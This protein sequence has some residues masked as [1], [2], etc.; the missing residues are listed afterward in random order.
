MARRLGVF[1]GAFSPVHIGHLLAARA[2]AEALR[3]DQVVFVPTGRSAFAKRLWPDARR[4]ACLRAALKGH[5]GF[6][7][8][9]RELR[10][11]G[12]SYTVDTLRALKAEQG[13][14]TRLYF[15]LGADAALGLAS[16]KEPE[17][18]AALAT[19]C[20]MERPG[21]SSAERSALKHIGKRFAVAHLV[22]PQVEV[23]S[24]QIRSRLAHHQRIDWLV[25]E[26]VRKLL[27][28]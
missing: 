8:D 10:R 3:L 4:L 17:A 11:K 19:F 20:I 22:I 15:L 14:G 13:E 23:S 26:A 9:A 12:V 7:V 21:L 6:C 1:G 16:W 25:P 18:L 24:S 5:P 27:M 2:A 28:K